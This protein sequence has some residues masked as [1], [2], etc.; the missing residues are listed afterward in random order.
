MC[1]ILSDTGKPP[2]G[3]LAIESRDFLC[4]NQ[5]F[6]VSLCQR[7]GQRTEGSTQMVLWVVS[8]MDLWF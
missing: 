4:G 1:R 6:S 7:C 2:Q 3:A 5:R 8:G